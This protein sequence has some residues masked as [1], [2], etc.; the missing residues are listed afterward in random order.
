MKLFLSNTAAAALALVGAGAKPSLI[1]IAMRS[2]MA[3]E[4]NYAAGFLLVLF[5]YVIA[6][7]WALVPRHRSD[8]SYGVAAGPRDWQLR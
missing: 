3:T 5:F 6:A 7:I 2:L 4:G 1:N 8:T